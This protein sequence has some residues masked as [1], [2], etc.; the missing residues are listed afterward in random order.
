MVNMAIIKEC[1]DRQEWDDYALNSGS[2]PLQLWGWGEV[3]AKHGWSA[4]RLFM[5]N[6]NEKIMAAAQILV[7][8]LPWPFKSIAYIPRGPIVGDSDRGE[9]LN[10]LVKYVREKHHS[11]SLSIEPDSLEFATVKGWKKAKNHILPA[12][13]IVLDL[14]KT[15]DELL[16]DMAGKTRYCIRKSENSNIV[17]KSVKNEDQ[18]REC[19]EIYHQT[20]QRAKF[21]IHSDEYY[22]DVYKEMG[23]H[24]PI[25][26]AYVKGQPVAFSWMLISADVAV[27]LYGGMNDAGREVLAG[28]ALKW[29][30]IRKCKEWGL[31]RYDFGGMVDGGVSNFKISW[32]KTETKF[33][34]T[35]DYPLSVSYG[36]YSWVLPLGKKVIRRL[37]AKLALTK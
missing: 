4:D 11:V 5:L 32:A 37:K 34:G 23:E 22:I 9:L 36:L 28:Y 2:H 1:T 17:I 26:V 8:H 33:A 21:G 20:A 15:E 13:T 16:A 29:A 27:E 30:M 19:L 24:S 18:L 6:D 25:L 35:F 31:Q 14:K 12:E 7:R 10:L 3:K